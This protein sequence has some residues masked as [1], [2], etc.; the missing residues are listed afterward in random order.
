QFEEVE[1]QVLA[2]VDAGKTSVSVAKKKTVRIGED[3]LGGAITVK[4]L[5]PSAFDV[6][7]TLKFAIVTPGVEFEWDAQYYD[8]FSA[9]P[10]TGNFKGTT[11]SLYG[12]FNTERD[13]DK[14]IIVDFITSKDVPAEKVIFAPMLHVTPDVATGTIIQI[15][16]SG[17]QIDTTTVDV[18]KV[19]SENIAVTVKNADKDGIYRGQWAEFDDVEVKLDPG[20]EAD[21]MNYFTV[22]LPKG[23]YFV[24]EDYPDYLWDGYSPIDWDNPAVDFEGLYDNDQTAWFTV[25]TDTTTNI[26]LTNFELLADADA[27]VGDLNIEF[28]GDVEGTFKI[29]SIMNAFTV[30]TAPVMALK[31]QTSVKGADILITET[32]DEALIVSDSDLFYDID[33]N[34]DEATGVLLDV[35]LPAGVTFSD[36]PDVDVTDGDLEIGSVFLGEDDNI[37]FIEIDEQ[38]SDA[39][40]ITISNVEYTFLNQPSL[41]NLVDK[42][43]ADYN[44]VS[45]NPLEKL[46]FASIGSPT[47][48]FVIGA[49]TFT[50]NGVVM[51]VVTPSY[52]KNNRT[53]L[54]IRDIGTALG[55]EPYNILWDATNNRITMVKGDKIVQMTMGSMIMT[56]NGTPITMD[57]APE[58]NPAGDRSMLPAAFLAQ[59]FGATAYWDGLTNTVTIKGSTY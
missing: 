59:A 48:V 35:K 25:E 26:K 5:G 38:S 49:S 31:E 51:P 37:L 19:G 54:A 22:T 28:G 33:E 11:A 55:V 27:V 45:Y 41:G 21:Y 18:A 56:I 57:V 4:E 2:K 20:T 15:K 39:S 47:A 12:S 36:V 29:G 44:V 40:T 1:S 3:Q 42:I 58:W 23:V 13:T 6:D 7:Q 16:V 32:A 24:N 50:L 30:S 17:D 43:G 14:R 53:Y 46:T 8:D 10:A 52:V 34:D 9:V